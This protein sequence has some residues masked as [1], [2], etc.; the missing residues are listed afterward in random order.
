M[1]E[2]VKILDLARNMIRLAGQSV[3]DE[4]NSAD[5][6]EI[7]FTGLR[8][9]EKLYEEMLIDSSN[10]EGTAHPKI[11]RANEPYLDTGVMAAFIERL[12]EG[13]T[14]QHEN[15]VREILMEVAK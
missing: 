2:P 15:A 10:A 1:G 3:R 12:N 8:P 11:M 4:T 13:V 14:A 9:G 7:A 5:D 6:I